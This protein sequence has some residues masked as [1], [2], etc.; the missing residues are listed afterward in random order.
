[1]HLSAGY[2]KVELLMVRYLL[3]AN[4]NAEFVY[5]YNIHISE[6]CLKAVVTFE[7]YFEHL[8]EQGNLNIEAVCHI[9]PAQGEGPHKSVIKTH[10]FTFSRPALKVE[11]CESFCITYRTMTISHYWEK[12]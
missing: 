8:I 6:K 11:V 9:A 10:N 3:H 7:E 4:G 1:M 5:M 2:I 12:I